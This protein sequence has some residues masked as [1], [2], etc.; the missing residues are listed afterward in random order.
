M[1]IL[2]L[3]LY[4]FPLLNGYKNLYRFLIIVRETVSASINVLDV[5]TVLMFYVK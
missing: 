2:E 4:S 3:M 1:Y 5:I